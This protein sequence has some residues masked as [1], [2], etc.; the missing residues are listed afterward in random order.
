MP[1]G[2]GKGQ[3]LWAEKMTPQ[4]TFLMTYSPFVFVLF[5]SH[6]AIEDKS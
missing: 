3:I 4:S 5:L 6:K 2:P 1:L